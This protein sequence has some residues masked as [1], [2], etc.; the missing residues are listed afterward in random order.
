MSSDYYSKRER[1]R[2]LSQ[3]QR[4]RDHGV[5]REKRKTERERREERGQSGKK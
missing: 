4:K 2:G 1:E 3:T 5:L